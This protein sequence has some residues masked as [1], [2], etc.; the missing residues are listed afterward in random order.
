MVDPPELMDIEEL[1]EPQQS[2]WIS[3]F[4]GAIFLTDKE[5]GVNN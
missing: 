3:S 5:R 2:G 1:D 4:I